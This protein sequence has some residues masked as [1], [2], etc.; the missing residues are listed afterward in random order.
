MSCWQV[1]P[2]FSMRSA[3]VWSWNGKAEKEFKKPFYHLRANNIGKRSKMFKNEAFYGHYFLSSAVHI[4]TIAHK[5][6]FINAIKIIFMIMTLFKFF[7][8]FTWSMR[9]SCCSMK[10][11]Q[12]DREDSIKMLH[13]STKKQFPRMSH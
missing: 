3:L 8:N 1:W 4:F 11:A 9:F 5:I 12:L 2:R 10:S 7:C 13:I 6:E